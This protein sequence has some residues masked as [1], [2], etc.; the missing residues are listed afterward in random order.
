MRSAWG[1]GWGALLLFVKC[2]FQFLDKT[3]T[4]QRPVAPLRS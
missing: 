4:G 2:R 1:S 3:L